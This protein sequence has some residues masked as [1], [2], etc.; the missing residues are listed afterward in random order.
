MAGAPVPL[1]F[2]RARLPVGAGG[3]RGDRQGAR[4]RRETYRPSRLCHASAGRRGR[5]RLR[6]V[7]PLGAHLLRSCLGGGPGDPQIAP[8]GEGVL[9]QPGVFDR[10][11][12]TAFRPL[13]SGQIARVRRIRLRPRQQREL[14]LRLCQTE[15]QIR[16]L[17]GRL[18][19]QHLPQV[20][21]QLPCA[22]TAGDRVHGH[23]PLEAFADRAD[24][25][26]PG[27]R[28]G[29]RAAELQRLP[30]AIGKSLARGDALH[31]ARHRVFGVDFRRFLQI[32]LA[33]A[34]LEPG[35]LRTGD[36]PRVHRV[37]LRGKRG[38]PAGRRDVPAR[39]ERRKKHACRRAG[40]PQMPRDGRRGVPPHGRTLQTRQLA[41]RPLP[42]ARRLR[43]L[44]LG[45]HEL[46]EA[47]L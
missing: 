40:H 39:A 35:P 3:A 44:A 15:P 8:R 22:G 17:S 46:A 45:A 24:A 36:H 2:R 1:P 29:V 6:Q 37:L 16:D 33:A 25:A 4:N 9:L 18:P 7:P 43:R 19:G 27:L 23:R 30:G 41:V 11:E 28:R 26:R 20:A 47:R 42:P 34:A 31:R 14:L 21:A 32:L 12:Q 13:L 10:V 5:L 38:R